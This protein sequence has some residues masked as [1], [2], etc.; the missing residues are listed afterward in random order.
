M[1]IKDKV[2]V[3]TGGGS[4]LGAATARW[5]S[6]QGAY[7]ALID[8]NSTTV[9]DIADEIGAMVQICNVTEPSAVEQAI[10]TII[11]EL[12]AIHVLVNCAGIVA[13]ERV[14]GREGPM[15]LENFQHVIQVNLIGTFN[16]LRITAARMSAQ[17]PVTPDGERGVIV[18]TA[19]VA[20]YEGQ[21]GQA[22]YS[23]SKG[24]IVSMTLPIARELGRWGIR[25][26]AI[27]PGVMA[28]PMVGVM[29]PSVEQGL[30]AAVVFPQRLGHP[31][32]FSE[33]VEHIIKNPYLNGSV[34]RLDGA[35]RL[36]PNA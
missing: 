19:S 3:V 25:V 13:A 15:P 30:S 8:N 23:A 12:D 16:V 21:L 1:D 24:G 32:E 4:G 11:T 31:Q 2:V 7:V 34:I 10:D 28:T 18:N 35:L 26:M 36:A 27:A 14:V 29:P 17:A 33:L 5:L 22:A 20:A 6:K 9:A